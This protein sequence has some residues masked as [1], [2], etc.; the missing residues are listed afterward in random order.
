MCIY[1]YVCVHICAHIHVCMYVLVSILYMY[2]C[3]CMNILPF[4]SLSVFDGF[5]VQN[6][7]TLINVTIGQP[8]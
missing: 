4:L 1:V 5:E 8:V 7:T 6:T 2:M 3:T